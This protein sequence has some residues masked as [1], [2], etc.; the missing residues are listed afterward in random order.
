MADAACS[1]KCD[2]VLEI[3]AGTGALTAALLKRFTFVHAVER[4]RELIPILRE[5]FANEIEA[6]KLTLHEKDGARF[7]I[8]E[9][10]H[11]QKL[12][13][14]GNLPYHLTSSIII[15]AL[16]HS[17][18]LKGAVFLV[19]KEVADRLCAAPRTKDYGFLTVLLNLAFSLEKIARVD[20]AS[21]WPVPR[22]DSAIIKMTATD[23]GITEIADL[24]EFLVFVRG[25]FQKRR[26]KINTILNK[27]LDHEQWSI[28]AIS[29]DQRPEELSSEQFLNLF[30]VLKA[31]AGKI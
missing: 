5:H 2:T 29:P 23:R 12:A 27:K 8:K 11:D 22:V 10:F 16:K 15:L 31:Q 3:G 9:F 24:D 30:K 20:R 14:V 26:K 18:L 1:F 4:D 21:F 13:M 25:I 19:Q 7:D 6:K 28:L 17:H